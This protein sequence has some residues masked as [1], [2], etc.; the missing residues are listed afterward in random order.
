MAAILTIMLPTA[1]ATGPETNPAPRAG[2]AETGRASYHNIKSILDQGGDT[3]GYD[4]L[5]QVHQLMI[6]APQPVFRADQLLRELIRKRNEDPRVDQMI[7]IFAAKIIGG[8]R[9][10]IPDARALLEAILEQDGRLNE[11]VISF[12]AEA[13]GDYAWDL[14]RGDDLVD[15]MEAKLAQIKSVDRS[16]EEYFG[17]H[18]LPPPRS[19]FIR[20][21]ISGIGERRIR[22]QERILYYAMIKNGLT[23]SQIE[24]ALKFL[25][26][27]G[28]PGSGEKCPDLMQCLMR[29]R[30]RLPFP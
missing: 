19:T 16:Q 24:T 30:S 6:R 4:A 28:A 3:I 8:S 13:I 22:Q 5:M 18:F 9:Y 20:A 23:E 11:W 7:L 25:K 17:F 15:M 21:Y 27:H 26:T 10:I 2:H 12:V 14:P 29:Y 1:C